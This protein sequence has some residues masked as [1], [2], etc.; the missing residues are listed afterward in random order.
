MMS[1]GFL[2]N[3]PELAKQEIVDALYQRLYEVR[4]AIFGSKTFTR[5]EFELG[6]NYRL[7]REVDWLETLLDKIERS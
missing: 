4:N 3:K 1:V 7:D 5:D 2:S 6:I